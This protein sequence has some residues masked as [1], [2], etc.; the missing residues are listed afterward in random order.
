MHTHEY[1]KPIQLYLFSSVAQSHQNLWLQHARLPCPLPT[2]GA[3]SNSCPWSQWC[4]PTIVSSIVP[5]SSCFQ[6]FAASV[7]FPMSH[8]KWMKYICELYLSKTFY[9]HT[10]RK[11]TFEEE[12]KNELSR[13]H[14]LDHLWF[15]SAVSET[16]THLPS[17]FQRLLHNRP[18]SE[19][20]R[21][22]GESPQDGN[23]RPY[24]TGFIELAWPFCHV[25]SQ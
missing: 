3:C 25:R 11:R 7:S 5:F 18:T 22:P 23:W 16:L 13:I 20:I 2:P 21:S 17:W 12:D 15:T 8:F 24:E 9:T 1:N 14:R 4:H 6:S 19:L 10:Q